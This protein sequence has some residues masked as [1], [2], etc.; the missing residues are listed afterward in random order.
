MN[1]GDVAG[2]QGDVKIHSYD[3]KEINNSIDVSG[4]PHKRNL[5]RAIAN[6]GWVSR[7][8]DQRRKN[9]EVCFNFRSNS[10]GPCIIN[11]ITPPKSEPFFFPP[12][13]ASPFTASSKF[14]QCGLSQMNE[15]GMIGGLVFLMHLSV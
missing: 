2:V 4:I 1:G 5:C 3:T 11:M 6:G 9:Y 13:I 10:D 7:R 14:I 12:T 8:H 15:F